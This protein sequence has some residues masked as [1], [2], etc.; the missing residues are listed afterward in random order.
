MFSAPATTGE[1]VN[2][3]AR[4]L[5]ICARS[6]KW[7]TTASISTLHQFAHHASTN[8]PAP[9]RSIACPLMR[10]APRCS[11]QEGWHGT[12]LR[13]TILTL[14]SVVVGNGLHD[15]H[16][17]G[18]PRLASAIERLAHH[19]ALVAGCPLLHAPALFRQPQQF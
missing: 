16:P 13:S 15:G 2:L 12:I 11:M 5:R 14:G 3:S 19:L 10:H 7:A 17:R 8:R 4:G 18:R 1:P 9:A 6:A